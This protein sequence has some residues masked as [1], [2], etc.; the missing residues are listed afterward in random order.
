[1][2]L[3][4]GVTIGG[5]RALLPHYIYLTGLWSSCI[6]YA[7]MVGIFGAGNTMSRSLTTSSGRYIAYLVTIPGG[8]RGNLTSILSYEVAPSFTGNVMITCS[9]ELDN[10]CSKNMTAIG[11][12]LKKVYNISYNM[13]G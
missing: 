8:T 2:G 6:D 4:K 3:I 7:I 9:N 11:R 5:E 1:M 13:H 12:F 10:R